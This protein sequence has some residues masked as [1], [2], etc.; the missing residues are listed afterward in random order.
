MS[1]IK[2]FANARWLV[3]AAIAMAIHGRIPQRWLA[4]LSRLTR[5]VRPGGFAPSLWDMERLG[6]GP[7][8]M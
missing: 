1:G 2:R 7:G 8:H 4:R 3:L 5:T 6:G